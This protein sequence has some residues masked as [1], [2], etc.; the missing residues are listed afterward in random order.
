MVVAYYIMGAALAAWMTTG[1]GHLDWRLSLLVLPIMYLAHVCYNAF[2]GGTTSQSLVCLTCQS[3]LGLF[4]RL[5]NHHFCCDEH[6][7]MY[8]AQLQELALT[9]LHNAIA[10]T[11]VDSG[12]TAL[13]REVKVNRENP[14]LIT[15]VPPGQREQTQ[16]LIVLPKLTKFKPSPA[17][18]LA[19]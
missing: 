5:T 3:N 10:V 1:N 7:A 4:R 13:H 9:R 15:P 2:A 11:S 18:R 14:E 19:E 12:E 6:E 17:Y 8:L 16:A